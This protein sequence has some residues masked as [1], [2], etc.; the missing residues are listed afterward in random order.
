MKKF[1]AFL[2]FCITSISLFSQGDI[3]SDFWISNADTL[4]LE[5]LKDSTYHHLTQTYDYYTAI[6]FCD[7]GISLSKEKDNQAYLG[8]FYSYKGFAY[9]KLEEYKEAE[10]FLNISIRINSIINNKKEQAI[11][12]VNIGKVCFNQRRYDEAMDYYNQNLEICINIDRIKGIITSYNNIGLIY[13]NKGDYQTAIT[14]FQQALDI[15]TENNLKK[16]M[17]HALENL[18]TVYG[19]SGD[20]ELSL[21]YY[22]DSYQI[23]TELNDKS[24]IINSLIN[25]GY[26]Q[27]SLG[28]K[29]EALRTYESALIKAEEYGN[30]M[31]QSAVCANISAIY[32][33][34]G[35]Y[36]E[37]LEYSLRSYQISEDIDR[38]SGL[39]VAGINIAEANIKLNRFDLAEQYLLKALNVSDENEIVLYYGDIYKTF[40]NLYRAK[41]S[42][43]DAYDYVVLAHA[44]QDTL[45]N[46]EIAGQI[47]DL[48]I[49]YETEKKEKQIAIQELT[50]INQKEDIAHK[51]QINKLVIAVLLVTIVFIVFISLLYLQKRKAYKLLVQQNIA[52]AKTETKLI[53]P[54]TEKADDIKYAGSKLSDEQKNKILDQLY[55]LMQN[56]EIFLNRQLCIEDV[57]EMLQTNRKYLSQLINEKFGMNFNSYINKFRVHKARKLLIDPKY[58]NYTIEAIANESGFHS[59][60]TFN[61]AFKKIAGVTP[62][63]L[64]NNQ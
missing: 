51:N 16:N 30:R 22:N 58:S 43:Q 25:I 59:K 4:Q 12:L 24:G 55:I 60:A 1:F 9:L 10:E 53:I 62:S 32:I 6:D 34:N 44:H 49:K 33:A 40:S 56:D 5:Q 17:S 46:A 57:A 41:G 31:Q 35:L 64:R 26:A 20:Y 8:K 61:T 7:E 14:S 54:Q 28:D 52:I 2:V 39:V 50:I 27:S 21:K 47:E 19:K 23:K 18:G 48:N 15:A 11:S 42:Y 63:F 37:S 13:M 45:M 38:Y 3:F 36:E 29:E